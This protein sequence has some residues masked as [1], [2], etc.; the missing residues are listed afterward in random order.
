ML[1]IFRGIGDLHHSKVKE[2]FSR[3]CAIWVLF[4]ATHL[5]CKSALRR[6][7]DRLNTAP[8]QQEACNG[9]GSCFTPV[10]VGGMYVAGFLNDRDLGSTPFLMGGILTWLN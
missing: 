3:Q 1:G 4:P 8:T 2:L 6:P 5:Q 9:P 10:L 7:D